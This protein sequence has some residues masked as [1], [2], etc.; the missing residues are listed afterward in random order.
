[1]TAAS[2]PASSSPIDAGVGEGR[3]TS[4]WRLDGMRVVITGS[5][6]GI[7]KAV[8]SELLGLGA[9]VL[10]HSRSAKDVA[11]RVGE[12]R[13]EHGAERVHG[14]AADISAPERRQLLISYV[15]NLWGRKLVSQLF[16]CA[17]VVQLS[18]RPRKRKRRTGS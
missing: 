11:S 1:M 8:A 10:I 15:T 18:L 2:C 12:W 9:R 6:K 3:P 4:H 17:A 16:L 14:Y 13:A 7:G 5:T